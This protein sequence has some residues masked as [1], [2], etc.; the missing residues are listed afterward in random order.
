MSNPSDFVIEDGVLKKYVGPGGDVVIPEGVTEIG[1][2]AFRGCTTLTSVAIPESVMEI[3]GWAFYGCTGLVRISIPH[4]VEMIGKRAFSGCSE[5]TGIEIPAKVTRL[6]ESAFFECKKLSHVGLPDALTFIGKEAFAYCPCLSGVTFPDALEF[7]GEKAFAGCESLTSIELPEKVKSVEKAT[8]YFCEGLKEAVL[9]DSVCSIGEEAFVWCTSLESI[10]LPNSLTKIGK[11]AFDACRSLLSIEIPDGV[12][13]IEDRTFD[14]CERLAEVRY[15]YSVKSIGERAFGD[16]KAIT[17]MMIKGGVER[18]AK[19]AFAG[20]GIIAF[21][22]SPDNKKF[23]GVDGVLY[24]KNLKKLIAYPSAKPDKSYSV[25]E[26]TTNLNAGSVQKTNLELLVLPKTVESLPKGAVDVPYVVCWKDACAWE[27]ENPI[28]LGGKLDKLPP[29]KKNGTVKGFIYAREH[30]IKIKEAYKAS[31]VEH[32][33]SNLKTY[34][35]NLFE[36]ESLFRFMLEEELIPEKECA[37]LLKEAGTQSN[38]ELI[39]ALLEYQET[40]FGKVKGTTSLDDRDPEFEL[41]QKMAVRREQLRTQKGIRGIAFVSTGD[42]KHFGDHDY[43]GKKNMSDL[44]AFIEARGGSYRSAVSS[45][46]DFL[47]C[48]DPNSNSTKSIEA[49]ELG[50]PVITEDEFMKMAEETE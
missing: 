11:G 35:K 9:P 16:C 12:T 38:A 6:E 39:V 31:Y 17:N 18:I 24:S 7:V 22:V 34:C 30:G 41:R 27:T 32:I 10:K 15:S 21:A 29:Q 42:L 19:N 25:P 5:L 2:G 49:K 44:K 36:N 13:E 4:S 14:R 1:D 40:H 37:K 23:A 50:I 46:T 28:F 26:G 33:R 20:A 8:F 43:S 47:I 48:N 45:K 3:G